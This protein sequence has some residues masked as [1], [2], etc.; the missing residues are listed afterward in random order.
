MNYLEIDHF[1][2]TNS[3]L[4]KK[5]ISISKERDE[6]GTDIK[7]YIPTKWKDEMTFLIAYGKYDRMVEIL[8]KT[9]PE[10]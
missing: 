2:N 9:S 3:D 7:K 4:C 6:I 1:I 10:R 8:E 5:I